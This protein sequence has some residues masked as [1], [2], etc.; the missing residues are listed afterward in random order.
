MGE[1][2]RRGSYETRKRLAI[3]RDKQIAKE[4]HAAWVESRLSMTQEE[5]KAERE[6]QRRFA[7]WIGVGLAGSYMN[8]LVYRNPFN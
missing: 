3:E 2:K 7:G 1:T 5:L 8:P 4:K 6:A